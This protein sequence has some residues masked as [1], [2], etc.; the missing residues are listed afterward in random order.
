[1][2]KK[3]IVLGCFKYENVEIVLVVDGCVIVYMGDDECGEFFYKFV[4]KD[5]YVEGGSIEGFLSDG[6]FY[7]V[8][9]NDDLSGEWIVLMLEVIGMMLE[10]ICIYIRVV[11]FKVGVIIMDW[12]EWVVV[13]FLKVEV[14]C[15]LINNKNC[16]L[17]INVGGDEILV[18]G[19]NL[20]EVN[21]FGQI[22]CWCL[23]NGDYIDM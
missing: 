4:F 14:Y 5:V 12:F 11:G 1:M 22:V 10:E 8:K 6:Q 7:V 17:K 23:V 13:N 16:G 21:M 18:G 20:C 9:F 15:V 19:F 2:L 3:C